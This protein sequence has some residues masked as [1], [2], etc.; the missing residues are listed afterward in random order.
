MDNIRYYLSQNSTVLGITNSKL[1]DACGL[2]VSF[3]GNRHGDQILEDAVCVSHGANN[4]G[5]ELNLTI[6]LSAMNNY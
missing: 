3:V 4:L 6:I 5:K 1:G 2:M